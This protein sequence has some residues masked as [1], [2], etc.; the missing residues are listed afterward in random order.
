MTSSPDVAFAAARSVVLSRMSPDEL[1]L[2]LRD[3]RSV[4][5]CV[6]AAEVRATR[7]GRELE[8]A[9]HAGSPVTANA[10]AGGRSGREARAVCE[11]EAMCTQ[12]PA[13]EAALQ[14]GQV[15]SGHVDAVAFASR[16]LDD[17]ARL[18][19]IDLSAAIVAEASSSSV[20]AFDRSVRDLAKHIIA[21]RNEAA[22]TNELETQRRL[23][24]VERWVD[25]AAGM[26]LTKLSL[27]PVRDSTL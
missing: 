1:C 22:G 24:K 7:R 18:E 25:G 13:L 21:S 5:A 6:D 14:A 16:R 19:F 9:G 27:D 10:D 4:R 15:S 3:L 17:A 12:M 11:R 20:D 23:S 2:H 8:A 26:H